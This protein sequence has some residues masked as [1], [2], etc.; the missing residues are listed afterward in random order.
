MLAGTSI[1]IPL[2][3]SPCQDTTSSEK[4]RQRQSWRD[5]FGLQRPKTAKSPFDTTSGFW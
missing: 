1:F 4:T 3:T 2:Q 5:F